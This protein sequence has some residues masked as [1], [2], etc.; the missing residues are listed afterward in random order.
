MRQGQKPAILY[1][2][3]ARVA[4]GALHNIDEENSPRAFGSTLRKISIRGEAIEAD[5]LRGGLIWV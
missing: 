3:S 4:S 5:G 1:F 2:M